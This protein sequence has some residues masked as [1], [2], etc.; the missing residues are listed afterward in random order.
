[1]ALAPF[2][3]RKCRDTRAKLRATEVLLK[4]TKDDE[5]G[6]VTRPLVSPDAGEVWRD[7]ADLYKRPDGSIDDSRKRTLARWV[8]DG[9][10]HVRKGPDGLQQVR[11]DPA[12]CDRP[13]W[14]DK[15]VP[16]GSN[17]LAK[18]SERRPLD[19]EMVRAG[20]RE[21]AAVLASLP[22]IPDV[23]SE[24]LKRG[25]PVPVVVARV[26]ARSRLITG[27][28]ALAGAVVVVLG[29]LGLFSIAT[30]KRLRLRA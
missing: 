13:L 14:T 16:A 27:L 8:A 12:D 25:E 2:T 10:V 19:P 28:I 9:W 5:E 6:E 26:E 22:P 18:A 7:R 21:V 4:M 23:A 29:A 24:A 30:G 3:R 15:A 1:L 20:V 11:M 17:G